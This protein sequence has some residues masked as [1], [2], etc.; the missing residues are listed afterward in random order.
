MWFYIKPLIKEIVHYCC[1]ALVCNEFF[2][3]VERVGP[4]GASFEGSVIGGVLASHYFGVFL[5]LFF[6][7]D[8]CL[9]GGQGGQTGRVCGVADLGFAGSFENFAFDDVFDLRSKGFRDF[10][11]SIL[12]RGGFRLVKA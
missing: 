10:D 11:V 1:E 4:A 8:V 3:V 2:D 12:L 7:C 9:V 5:E 6:C